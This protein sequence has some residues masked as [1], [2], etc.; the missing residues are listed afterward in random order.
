[1]TLVGASPLTGSSEDTTEQ[2]FAA[3]LGRGSREHSGGSAAEEGSAE[4]FGKREHA[5]HTAMSAPLMHAARPSVWADPI[6]AC[7]GVWLGV[8]GCV[9]G[10]VCVLV[11]VCVCVFVCAYASVCV[12]R[13][14]Y[15]VTTSLW[16]IC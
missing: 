14:V 16:S 8:T 10:C 11:C 4:A 2:Q 9:V 3:P 13:D 5:N 1:M 15:N 12:C 7:V 6:L